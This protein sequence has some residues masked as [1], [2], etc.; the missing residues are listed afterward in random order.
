VSFCAR[1]LLCLQTLFH[2][3]SVVLFL[4]NSFSRVCNCKILALTIQGPIAENEE[5]VIDC[6]YSAKFLTLVNANLTLTRMTIKNAFSVADG[7]AIGFGINVSTVSNPALFP[8]SLL[9]L[10]SKFYNSVS[11]GNGGGVSFLASD[12]MNGTFNNACQFS[13]FIT[14]IV[15]YSTFVN[16]SA[17]ASDDSSPESL[18]GGLSLI[19]DQSNTNGSFL[20]LAD[21]KFISCEAQAFGGGM[22]IR[23]TH[24]GI[25][26]G[27]FQ[28][29]VE[30]CVFDSCIAVWGGGVELIK[31]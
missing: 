24:P 15:Q 6:L 16:C 9:I 23:G 10:Q 5:A 19:F 14:L 7:G 12:Y 11:Q 25:Q 21:N 30:R 20:L 13:P 8:M 4:G 2:K 17:S 26:Q 29:S 3:V 31:V 27:H 22:F 28:L 1:E 18:G